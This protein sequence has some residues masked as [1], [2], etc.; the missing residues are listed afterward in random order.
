V[1]HD[2]NNPLTYIMNQAKM[3]RMLHPELETIETIRQQAAR[4]NKIMATLAK[5]VKNS[6]FR[7]VCLL[8]LNEILEEEVFFLESHPDYKHRIEKEWQ[9][10]ENLPYL[11]GVPIEFSQIFGNILRNA[12]EAMSVQSSRRLKISS[13]YDETNIYI[14]IVDNGP[15]VP[16]ELGDKIFEPFVTTKAPAERTVGDIGMGIG[17]YN[18][19]ELLRQY[20]GQIEVLSKPGSGATF[21]VTLPRNSVTMSIH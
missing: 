5:R 11:V 10:A 2:L 15:G 3:L 1:L 21:A 13:W 4:M 9:L 17:L 7:D 18:C 16:A 19:R 8:Q 12:A 6:K 20:G 14:T